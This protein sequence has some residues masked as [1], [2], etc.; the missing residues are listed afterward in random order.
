MKIL[1]DLHQVKL[2]IDKEENPIHSLGNLIKVLGKLPEI[3]KV[4]VPVKI[5]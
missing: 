2:S 1:K 5:D 4:T 3:K